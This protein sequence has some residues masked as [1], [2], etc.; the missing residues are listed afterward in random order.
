[1]DYQLSHPMLLEVPFMATMSFYHTMWIPW[2]ADNNAREQNLHDCLAVAVV[3]VTAGTTYRWAFECR[4]F[5]LLHRHSTWAFAASTHCTWC[6]KLLDHPSF[7][8]VL[9]N[10]GWKLAQADHQMYVLFLCCEIW[11]QV[12]TASQSRCENN[13]I[14]INFVVNTTCYV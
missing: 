9:K 14:I 13:F 10:K 3:R 11:P 8:G 7:L 1:M 5:F 2:R 4:W 12:G 6:T